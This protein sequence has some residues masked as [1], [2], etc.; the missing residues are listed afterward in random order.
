M[1]EKQK[2]KDKYSNMKDDIFVPEFRTKKP[3][4]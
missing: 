1:E 3:G 2:N 4:R